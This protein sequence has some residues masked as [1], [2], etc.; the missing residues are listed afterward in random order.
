MSN[1]ADQGSGH[2]DFG[3]YAAKQVQK[4]RPREGQTPERGVIEVKPTDED[5]WITA[6]GAQVSRYWQQYQQVLVT[7]FRDFVLVGEDAGR[8]KKPETFRLAESE[9]EFWRNVEKPRVFAWHTMDSLAAALSEAGIAFGRLNDIPGLSAH[10]QL[11][12]A[13]VSTPPARSRS[14]HP[15][16]A[17]KTPP[18]P[19]AP[20]PRW[21]SRAGR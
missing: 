17:T 10:P 7:N 9:D 8:L 20:S 5:A 21:A 6:D 18:A 13:A 15:P 19:S 12:R 3:L 4:D 16:P 1:L 11:R 14:S 2:P